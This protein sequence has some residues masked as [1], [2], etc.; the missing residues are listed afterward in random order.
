MRSYTLN[1]PLEYSKENWESLLGR[2]ELHDPQAE[3]NV[4][5]FEIHKQMNVLRLEQ[6]TIGGVSS[7]CTLHQCCPC[8]IT[9]EDSSMG[10]NHHMILCTNS[11]DLPLT[12]SS[13]NPTNYGF[14]VSRGSSA[15][16]CDRVPFGAAH[17]GVV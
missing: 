13:L 17:G 5:C 15:M 7:L 9:G 6:C 14:A 10:S 4:E 2:Q 8:E 12:T 11:I 1:T 3:I 16:S